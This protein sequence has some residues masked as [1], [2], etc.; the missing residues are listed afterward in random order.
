MAYIKNPNTQ[1]DG[2]SPGLLL[3]EIEEHDFW[4]PTFLRAPEVTAR[5]KEGKNT[6]AKGFTCAGG[7]RKHPAVKLGIK[8][9]KIKR[10]IVGIDVVCIFGGTLCSVLYGISTEST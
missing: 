7:V 4:E 1:N 5:E 6:F 2:W 9:P 10:W 3:G 8:D